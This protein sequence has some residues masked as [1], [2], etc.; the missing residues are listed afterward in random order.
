MFFKE[1]SQ[2]T[3]GCYLELVDIQ[4]LIDL[5]VGIC[6][7][8]ADHLDDFILD[9]KNRKQ[10]TVSKEKLILRLKGGD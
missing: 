6:M 3:S 9:L 5:L 4:D 7:K 1:I 8:E 10:L 2:T